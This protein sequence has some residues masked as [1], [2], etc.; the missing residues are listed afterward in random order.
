MFYFIRETKHKLVPI[1][2]IRVG[3]TESF[4]GVEDDEM[5][6]ELPYFFGAAGKIR[7]NNNNKITF[8][9]KF[10]FDDDKVIV[11]RFEICDRELYFYISDNKNAPVT[12]QVLEEEAKVIVIDGKKYIIIENH[13][14]EVK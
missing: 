1:S 5:H 6:D 2:S 9:L 10:G 14:I 3:K 13:A 12:K 11:E 7:R 4:D 8:K